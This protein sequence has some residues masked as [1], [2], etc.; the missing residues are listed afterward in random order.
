M[1]Q[2]AVSRDDIVAG[3]RRAGLGGGEVVLVHSSLSSFGW[4]EGGAEGVIEALRETVG[5]DGTI[6]M[7]AITITAEFVA[8]HVRAAIRGEINR[9]YPVFDVE[10]TPT[11]AGLIAE[12]FRNM[13]EAVR[14]R[15]PSHSVTALGPKAGELL[16]DHDLRPSCGQ[17]SPYERITRLD[18]GRVLLLGVTH[19]SSTTIHAFEE[20]A[21]AEYV[22]HP[23]ICRIPFSTP[24]GERIATTTLHV[25]HIGR[26]LGRLESRYID[27]GAET[28]TIIGRA[29]V[30]LCR[31][32]PL[33]EITLEAMRKSPYMLLTPGGVKAWEKM[34]AS[35]EYLEPHGA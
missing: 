25:Y 3:L 14:S 35:G 12:T 1:K 31:A 27:A 26:E 20:L 32:K 15:H 5:R 2:K 21:G 30:R 28:V 16:A 22:V 23:Q 4:V 8:A 17:D 33:R 11:W 13:P 10:K 7:S 6:V 34:K 19:E 18:E 24:E 29:P 9:E